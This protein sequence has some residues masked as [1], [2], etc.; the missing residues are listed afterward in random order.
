MKTVALTA[1]SR[2]TVTT[3]SAIRERSDRLRRQA[4]SLSVAKR[5]ESLQRGLGRMETACQRLERVSF[6]RSPS[7]TDFA[8]WKR[9]ARLQFGSPGFDPGSS[10]LPVAVLEDLIERYR[11]TARNIAVALR[12]SAEQTARSGRE[13]PTSCYRNK[14]T[15]QSGGFNRSSV[16]LCKC[17]IIS[18]NYG[19]RLE[20]VDQAHIQTSRCRHLEHRRY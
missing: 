5:V 17:I 1:L 15:E 8:V 7:E 20:A 6:V 18:E 19:C 13:P 16:P 12:P 14:P 2:P 4:D 11:I 3:L 9:P 10:R